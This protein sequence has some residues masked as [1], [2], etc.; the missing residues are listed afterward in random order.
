MKKSGE[1]RNCDAADAR[2]VKKLKRVASEFSDLGAY[3]HA[4]LYNAVCCVVVVLILVFSFLQEFP[5]IAYSVLSFCDGLIAS[6]LALCRVHI[7]RYYGLVE[8]Q[9]GLDV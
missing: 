9:Y 2:E 6:Q 4:A 3:T 7:L 8:I 1:L 5:Y